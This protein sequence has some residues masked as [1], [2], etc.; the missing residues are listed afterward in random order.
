MALRL[1]VI[2][3]KHQL[4]IFFCNCDILMKDILCSVSNKYV[5]FLHKVLDITKIKRY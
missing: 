5:Y 1:T 2:I 4:S 3:K